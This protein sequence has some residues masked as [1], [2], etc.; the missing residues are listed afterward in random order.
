MGV[1]VLKK[2]SRW[3]K[4]FEFRRYLKLPTL[5]VNNIGIIDSQGRQR[6]SGN[7]LGRMILKFIY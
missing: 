7:C 1:V 5:A 4:C 2:S 3:G 6:K